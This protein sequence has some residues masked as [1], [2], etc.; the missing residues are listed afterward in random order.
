[1]IFDNR[2]EDGLDATQVFLNS[3]AICFYE[4]VR[5]T[6]DQRQAIS[7]SY[8]VSDFCDVG[9]LARLLFKLG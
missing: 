4:V 5:E 9:C 7:D 3:T 6:D 1:M 8:R 2:I